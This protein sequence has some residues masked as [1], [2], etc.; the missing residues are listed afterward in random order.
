MFVNTR[1]VNVR[2]LFVIVTGLFSLLS[3]FHAKIPPVF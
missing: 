3:P 2:L 1:F